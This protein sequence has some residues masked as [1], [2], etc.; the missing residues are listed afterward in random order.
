MGDDVVDRLFAQGLVVDV[1]DDQ[2]VEPV[3]AD[4]DQAEDG[5]PDQ[6]WNIH[7]GKMFCLL[8][9]L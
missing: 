8:S 7:C 1:P 3:R 5:Q 2:A 9:L 4:Q 6:V